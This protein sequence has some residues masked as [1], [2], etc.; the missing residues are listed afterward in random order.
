VPGANLDALQQSL[1]GVIDALPVVSGD[2]RG[3]RVPDL[4]RVL[5]LSDRKAQQGGDSFISSEIVLQAL[6]EAGGPWLRP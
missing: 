1:R 3:T 6:L 4:S 5:N 2:R